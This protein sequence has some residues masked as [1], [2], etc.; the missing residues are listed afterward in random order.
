MDLK[1]YKAVI[2][3]MD[4]TLVDS[5]PA[6]IDAW[7]TTCEAHGIPVDR[8]WF[9]TMGGSPTLNTAKALIEKYQLDAD[10]VYLAES[11]LRNF[12]DIKQ[13]G[14]VITGTFEILKQAKALGMPS[15][16]G[17]G[18]Q[19]RHALEILTAAGLMSLLDEIVTAN[20]VTQH[21][22][23]PETFLQ[24]AEKLGVAAK[25][26][27]VF[28]DTELGCQAAKAAGMDCYLVADGEITAFRPAN[29]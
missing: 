19:R 5:M 21:K 3:D 22:P 7:Q 15:A 29:I 11:K 26:C 12:D 10:P 24:A 16:I 2:F 14:E 23:F 25:D 6:H 28:E 13:K 9:Y 8:D 27:V 18:C 1:Q 20:E 4:G 17:T